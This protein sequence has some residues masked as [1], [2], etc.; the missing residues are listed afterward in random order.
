MDLRNG[1]YTVT[2]KLDPVINRVHKDKKII[3][4]HV[5]RLLRFKKWYQ[6]VNLVKFFY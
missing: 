3:V 6:N 1:P 4:V 5:Q 2:Q